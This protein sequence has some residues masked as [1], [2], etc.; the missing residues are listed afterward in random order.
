MSRNVFADLGFKDDQAAEMALRV[1]VAVG[2]KKVIR[3]RNLTQE[4][5]KKLFGVPQ[6]TISKINTL[7]LDGLSLTL[8]L[9]MLF[10]AGLPFNM[11]SNGTSQSV[12]VTVNPTPLAASS[13]YERWRV[14]TAISMTT[15]DATIRGDGERS[16]KTSGEWRVGDVTRQ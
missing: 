9:R 4:D 3:E 13:V 11:M 16:E 10:K 1:A 5:A 7:R 15:P 14:G 6:P 2:I 8:L 12:C